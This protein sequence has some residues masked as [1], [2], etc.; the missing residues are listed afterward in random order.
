M[1]ARRMLA[2]HAPEQHAG[3]RVVLEPGKESLRVRRFR[4]HAAE[5]PT[6]QR[7]DVPTKHR[8]D[9][10]RGRKRPL[11][12][13]E[14]ENKM[15]PIEDPLLGSD[16]HQ[17][18]IGGRHLRDKEIDEHHVRHQHVDENGKWHN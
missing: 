6:D 9:V 5:N 18:L 11:R 3:R 1:L 16:L 8:E 10:E 17:F 13:L 14:L 2:L 4:P 15:G 7:R 12:V